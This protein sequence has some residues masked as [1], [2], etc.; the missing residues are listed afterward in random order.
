MY[1]H[2]VYY[3]RVGTPQAEDVVVYARPDEPEWGLNLSVTEDG[4]Y[5]IIWVSHGTDERNRIHYIDFG[6]PDGPRIQFP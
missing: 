3:H 6:D 4:R 5:G 1:N 2:T